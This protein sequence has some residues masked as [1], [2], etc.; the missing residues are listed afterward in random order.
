MEPEVGLW[1]EP[2]KEKP[3]SG[4]PEE[5]HNSCRGH[6]PLGGVGM[7]W[8]ESRERTTLIPLEVWLI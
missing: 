2:E 4:V 5:P 8:L 6:D 7:A 1:G 3:P